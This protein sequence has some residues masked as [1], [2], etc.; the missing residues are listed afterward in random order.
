[1]I[2][3]AI[4]D[5]A[6]VFIACFSHKSLA[7]NKS[8]QNEELTVAIEQ[9][10]SRRPDVPWLIPVRFDD[11]EIPDYDIGPGR[12]L[13]SIH[14]ADLFGRHAKEGWYPLGR[15]CPKDSRERRNIITNLTATTRRLSRLRVISRLA[16]ECETTSSHLLV[17]ISSA[18][19]YALRQCPHIGMRGA[20]RPC[21]DCTWG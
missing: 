21:R 8:Y 7:R 16:F 14:R 10:R 5:D 3:R 18:H 20:W 6:L 17:L 13:R 12:T 4:T 19:K 2:R 15:G 11:C 9:L 1:M